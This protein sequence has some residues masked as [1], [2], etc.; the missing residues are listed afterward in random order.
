MHVERGREIKTKYVDNL[1]F[2]SAEYNQDEIYF[3]STNTERTIESAK[4]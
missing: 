1:K 2:I 4:A 3:R